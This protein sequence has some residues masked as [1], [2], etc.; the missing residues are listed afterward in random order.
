MMGTGKSID[1]KVF[2]P[3]GGA[4]TSKDLYGVRLGG[5]L[6]ELNTD[7]SPM[8]NEVLGNATTTTTATT[9]QQWLAIVRLARVENQF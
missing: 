8:K 1:R 5:R 3:S 9:I 4:F 2:S 6:N 7:Y